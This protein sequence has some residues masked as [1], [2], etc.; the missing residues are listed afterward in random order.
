MSGDVSPGARIFGLLLILGASALAQTPARLPGRP[1]PPPPQIPTLAPDTGRAP[2]ERRYMP[3]MI[4]EPLMSMTIQVMK[5]TPA[6]SIYRSRHFEFKSPVKLGTTAMKEICRAFESTH[7]LV[8]KLPWGI[9]PW[10]QGGP[11]F[12]AELYKTREDYLAS[13]APQWSAAIYSLKDRIFRIPFEEVG[14]V[15]RG[16]AYYL[17]GVI[18]NDT[19]THEVTHQMMHEYLRFM[20]IWMAEGTA[21]YTSNLPYTSGRYNVT[22]AVEAFKQMRREAG[23]TKRRGPFMRAPTARKWVGAENLWGYTTSIT[24]RRVIT[25]F[26]PDPPKTPTPSSG[27]PNTIP[28]RVSG[29]STIDQEMLELPNRYYS[30]HALVFYFMHFDG[31]GKATR[32][33]KFFDAIH[34]ERK[35]WA[36]FEKMQ[37]ELQAAVKKYL[38]EWEAFKKLP[39]VEDLGGG[40]IRYPSN[41]TPPAEPKLPVGPGGVD[42]NKVCAKHLGILL[43]GRSLADLDRDVRAAFTKAEV[44][45]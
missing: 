14:V 38:E 41:L 17:G 18:N 11:C 44:P 30:S 31:D 45:L 26:A 1:T 16:D 21:E 3:A 25:D 29:P 27:I 37:E 33:K 5:E 20:P 8:S 10:P 36:S 7:E 9:T 13:G 24:T 43:D 12:R 23:K 34:E 22:N 2:A 35:Q 42:P 39:G 15:S 28:V 19:I 6:E 32:L 40:R 4:S